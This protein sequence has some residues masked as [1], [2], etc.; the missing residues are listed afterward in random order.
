[1]LSRRVL[2]RGRQSFL[3]NGLD[4]G[5]HRFVVDDVLK[6]LP[7]AARRT[8]RFDLVV[9]DPPSF[10]SHGRAT[11]SVGSG[12]QDLVRG[13]F[14]V[15]APGGALLAVT[16]HKKTSPAKLR[17]MLQRAAEAA[18]RP[19]LSLKLQKLPLDFTEGSLGSE[20]AKSAWLELE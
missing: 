16:N 3:L 10:S 6:W 12:Y 13:V 7:R 14:E 20:S 18:Q 19:V 1:D 8:Q 4:P 11:F 5:L 15:L 9:L 2:A 17:A